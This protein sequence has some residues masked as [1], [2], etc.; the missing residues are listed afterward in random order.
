MTVQQKLRRII[1][2]KTVFLLGIAAVL[3]ALCYF[4]SDHKRIPA[5]GNAH[6]IYSLVSI[7]LSVVILIFVAFKIRYFQNLFGRE[8]TGTVVA[9]KR[10]VLTVKNIYI[11]GDLDNVILFVQCD[12]KKRKKRVKLLGAKV[13]EVYFVGDRIHRLKGTRFPINLTREAEQHI[14][15]ICGR[16]SCYGD[17]C[18]DCNV[19]Y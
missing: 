14:C 10:Q 15:P 8:W 19:K 5:Y 1:F 16:D 6:W 12:G 9:I 18:P 17:E 4:T 2:K 13:S 11:M 7:G 3:G